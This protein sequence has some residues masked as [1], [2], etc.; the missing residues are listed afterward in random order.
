[1]S[2]DVATTILTS[3]AAS[4]NLTLTA[5]RKPGRAAG[6]LATSKKGKETKYKAACV[7]KNGLELLLLLLSLHVL[8]ARTS[9]V[10]ISSEKACGERRYSKDNDSVHR[11]YSNYHCWQLALPSKLLSTKIDCCID[12]QP[13]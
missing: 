8:V 12:S 10:T 3:V 1:M 2:H 9:R 13:V 6:L 11:A 7:A 5:A 4:T